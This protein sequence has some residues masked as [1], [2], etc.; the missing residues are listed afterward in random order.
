MTITS[1]TAHEDLRKGDS[2]KAFLSLLGSGMAQIVEAAHM[3]K[4]LV[5]ND[6]DA[7]SKI[8]SLDRTLDPGIYPKLLSVA[9]DQLEPALL[10]NSAPAY[11]VLQG[12]P[13]S[14]QRAALKKGTVELVVDTRTRECVTVNLADVEVRH[15]PQLFHGGKLQNVDGQVALLKSREVAPSKTI[16]SGKHPWVFKGGACKILEPCTLSKK[17]AVLIIKG[18]GFTRRDLHRLAD[19]LP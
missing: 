17:E 5:D 18:L 9:D 6:P 2:P 16:S 15:I 19:E 1:V 8:R 12:L 4:R 11:K 13:V 14:E 10:L 3:L 7:I